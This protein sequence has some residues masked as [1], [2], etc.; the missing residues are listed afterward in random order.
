M[1]ARDRLVCAFVD[2]PGILIAIAGLIA[3]ELNHLKWIWWTEWKCKRC[4]AA[5]KDCA[6]HD[7]RWV[8]YL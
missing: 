7:R 4:G 3:L 1:R 5:N 6:C 2:R 8:M